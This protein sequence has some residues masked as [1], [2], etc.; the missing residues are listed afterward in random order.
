MAHNDTD[1]LITVADT[2]IGLSEDEVKMVFSRFWRADS[3]RNREQGGL[4]VGLAL[5][6]EII[7]Q[8]NGTIDIQS[9]TD[10]GSAFTIRLPLYN[11]ETERTSRRR[12]RSESRKIES[13]IDDAWND[14]DL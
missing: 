7:D 1:A 13:S 9:E 6:K 3:G 12:A 11:E 5:V 10:K 8:H 14:D 2:G 4:G